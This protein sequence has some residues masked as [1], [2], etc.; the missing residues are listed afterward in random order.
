MAYVKKGGNGGRRPGAGKK[1]GY[2]HQNTLDKIAARECVRQMVT[3][4]L[5][6][7]VGAQL[8]NA[9]GIRHLMLRDPKTGKFER[10]T[11]VEG[12]DA[13]LQAEDGSTFYIYTKDPSVQAFTD[14][15]NRALDKPKEQEQAI[16][17]TGDA[18][19]LAMLLAGRERARTGRS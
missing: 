17:V 14:L 13:A 5:S 2:R 8:E 4:S 15:L 16:K 19:R 10:V 7:L 9:R 3:A 18:G 6:E 11:S 1:K 12:I